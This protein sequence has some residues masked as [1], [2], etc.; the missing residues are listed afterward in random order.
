M[1]IR[2]CAAQ[3]EGERE[4]RRI[5]TF[6]PSKQQQR[7]AYKNEKNN[8]I[9]KQTSSFVEYHMCVLNAV[10]DNLHAHDSNLFFV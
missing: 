7:R 4:Q 9:N 10:L 8:V 1:Y 6:F 5:K 2:L 3:K